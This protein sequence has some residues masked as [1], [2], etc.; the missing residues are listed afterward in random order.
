MKVRL[1]QPTFSAVRWNA[2]GDHNKVNCLPNAPGV[3]WLPTKKGGEAVHPGNWV[4][5]NELG[6]SFVVA[7]DAFRKM[8]QEE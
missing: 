7:D 5:T 6:E 8:Y 4:L 3:G 2:A 1:K